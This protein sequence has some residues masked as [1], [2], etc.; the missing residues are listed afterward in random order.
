MIAIR[1]QEVL[2]NRE[3]H[4][5]EPTLYGLAQTEYAW[6]TCTCLCDHAIEV[7][8]KDAKYTKW[9]CIRCLNQH[10]PVA[11]APVQVTVGSRSMKGEKGDE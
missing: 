10:D 5:Q 6:C 7:Y 3:L 1:S 4:Q 11:T 9:T 8:A 2:I